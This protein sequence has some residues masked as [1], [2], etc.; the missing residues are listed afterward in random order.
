MVILRT[1]AL[2]GIF[3]ENQVEFDGAMIEQVLDEVF[4]KV[5]QG[6]ELVSCLTC[7]RQSRSINS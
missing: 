2:S 3:F 6:N 5:F 4:D 7:D 1:R